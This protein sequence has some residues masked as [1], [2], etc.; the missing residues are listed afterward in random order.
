MGL[1]KAVVE[2]IKKSVS[3]IGQLYPILVD[4]S[5]NIIDGNHRFNVDRNWKKIKLCNVKNKKSALIVKIISNSCR[6]VTSSS[7]K[8]KTLSELAKIYQ[9]E[10]IE[11]GNISKKIAEDTGMSY[12]WVVKYLPAKFK[13]N[14][15]SMKGRLATQRKANNVSAS[16]NNIIIVHKYN[17]TNFVNLTIKKQFYDEIEKVAELMNISSE[18]L[19]TR[20]LVSKLREIK[21][22]I[23]HKNQNALKNKVIRATS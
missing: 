22:K 2:E 4:N 19:I 15:Q 1:S 5:G 23:T 21:I 7:E 14:L 20:I 9:S 13:D 17:N 8:S 12:N 6:R 18:M 16:P 3:Q 10:G 11:P